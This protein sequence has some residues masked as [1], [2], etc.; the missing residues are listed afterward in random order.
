ME[1]SSGEVEASVTPRIQIEHKPNDD[2]KAVKNTK[3]ISFG[4]V[5]DRKLRSKTSLYSPPL[6]TPSENETDF[7]DKR[8][9]LGRARTQ[10]EDLG[11]R[12]KEEWAEQICDQGSLKQSTVYLQNS[13]SDYEKE[14]SQQ[15]WTDLFEINHDVGELEK[16]AESSR[17]R[18]SKRA[19]HDV[20]M[21]G[22]T[23]ITTVALE[24]SKMLDVVMNQSPEYAGLA[25]GAIRMLLVAHTNHSKLKQAVENYII[26]FGQEFG[27][28]NQLM[29]SH[30]TAKM[31]EAVSEAYA[32]FAKFL[33]K[34]VQFYKESKLTSAVKAFG[35]R[36]ETR[37]QPYVTQAE[38]AFKHIREIAQAG[39]FALTVQMEHTIKSIDAGNE[40]LRVSMRQ[41]TVDLRRQLK[42]ELRNEVQA[43][44]ESFQKNWISRF[45]QIM[46][47]STRGRAARSGAQQSESSPASE[48]L[49]AGGYAEAMRE[50]IQHG[51]A[52]ATFL[53]E[54]VTKAKRLQR[55]RDR[56]F[57]R[58]Q[59]TD[60]DTVKLNA[61]LKHITIYDIHSI[62][63]LFRN[64]TV[65][66]QL[67]ASCSSLLWIKTFR[68]S[69][70]ADWGSAFSA[71]LVQNAPKTE[72]KAILYHF[73][74]NHPSSRPVSTP[75]VFIQSLIMQLLQQYHKKFIR[76]AFPFTLEHFQDAQEDME[77]LWELFHS[78]CKEA[79][80]R[81]V[82]LI[83]DNLDNLQKGPE[84]DA[85]LQ[86]LLH[87]TEEES[88]VFKVFV[89]VRTSGTPKSILDAIDADPTPSRIATV[90]VPKSQ[91]S[92]VVAALL[93][94]QK[95][96]A[97]LPD[98]SSEPS[99]PPKADIQDLLESSEEDLLS[100][101]EPD[102]LASPPPISPRSKPAEAS[103]SNDA[104]DLDLSDTSLDFVK[105]DPF[106]SSSESSSLSGGPAGDDESDD[107]DS[108]DEDSSFAAAAAAA[109]PWPQKTWISSRLSSS[110]ES[111]PGENPRA[112]QRKRH[113]GRSRN[114]VEPNAGA[115]GRQGSGSE[116]S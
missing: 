73:C 2:A 111:D 102:K 46:V 68:R 59:D 104:S 34:A 35:F 50:P 52:T 96:P 103:L 32:A 41:D 10:S 51:V 116:S 65:R 54:Q 15:Q 42:L 107:D 43:S 61:R 90:T 49:V 91:Y 71:R 40:Q 16:L 57:P 105:A 60:N 109:A 4:N 48:T 100:E 17:R 12:V 88:R 106:A 81:C 74:G 84:Y 25:W 94:K 70:L 53:A 69:G 19:G 45:E 36:W 62:I 93:S 67:Q 9:K 76:K 21:D 11:P 86:G 30:P 24:Y 38:A 114:K 47:Q 39:H 28:V 7:P 95:R 75:M 101:K 79:E 108:H 55:F 64:D 8:S 14:A 82:W 92:R 98:Q 99:T 44:F 89:T 29:K 22:L 56:A 85:L 58:L 37:F 31:V 27:V 87:L 23:R 113:R 33:A 115:P 110:D 5:F 72:D 80:P 26:Q 66:D 78:C 6:L 97:R 1:S 3:R 77:E 18:K 112:K 83:I 13:V 20:G 63:G